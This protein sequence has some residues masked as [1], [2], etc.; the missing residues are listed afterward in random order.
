MAWEVEP[1]ERTALDVADVTNSLRAL[2]GR[3]VGIERQGERLDETVE[4]IDFWR[5]YVMDKVW[6]APGGWQCQNMSLT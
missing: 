1:S 4:I 2:M 3:N 6:E 5:W